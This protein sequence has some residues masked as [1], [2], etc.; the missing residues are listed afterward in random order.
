MA[1]A[2]GTS[3]CSSG[4][5]SSAASP[6]ATPPSG[7]V[8]SAPGYS[9]SPSAPASSASA[10]APAVV[11]TA[12]AGKLG[13]ILVD[14]EGHTLYLFEADKSTE[15]TCN[16]A[17]AAAWPPLLT[18]GNPTAGDSAQSGLLGTT[19]RSDGKMQVT[20]HGHPLYGYAGDA[21]PGDTNGEGLNQFGAA[22]YVID[23]S[24]QKV[25]LS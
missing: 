25:D 11:K 14:A 22:W 7:A 1:L 18:S 21:K 2:A 3:G 23:A 20:Y 19:K 17:C 8:S 5:G 16:G 6:S 12:K 24:G 4:G 13:T 15:S 9:Q 10:G